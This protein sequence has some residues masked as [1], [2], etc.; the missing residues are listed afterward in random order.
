LIGI[1]LI[2]LVPLIIDWARWMLE[3]SNEDF[4]LS[5]IAGFSPAGALMLAWARVDATAIPGALFQLAVAIALALLFYLT[6][7]KRRRAALDGRT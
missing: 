7:P 6:L 1:L 4:V 3:Y 5:S 2:W